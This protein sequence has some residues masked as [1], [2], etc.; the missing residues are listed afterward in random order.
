MKKWK[1][2]KGIECKNELFSY[3]IFR[4]V[5]QFIALGACK[6]C[7]F[8]SFLIIWIHL[9]SWQLNFIL[10]RTVLSLFIT[11][12]HCTLGTALVGIYLESSWDQLCNIFCTKFKSF[13]ILILSS[14]CGHRQRTWNCN[15]QP[16][17]YPYMAYGSTMQF[18]WKF[19][20]NNMARVG[21]IKTNCL[22]HSSDHLM[23]E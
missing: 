1:N 17:L 5:H 18:C 20:R 22:H 15:V 2:V 4:S 19:S 13:Y 23:E 11:T 14:Y 9:T 10:L 3:I 8:Y 7:N 6:L 21:E 12:R 16:V